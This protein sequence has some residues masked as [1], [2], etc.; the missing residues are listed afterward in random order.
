MD[1]DDDFEEEPMMRLDDLQSLNQAKVMAGFNSFFSK[2]P[3]F[4]LSMVLPCL[5]P[6]TN[7]YNVWLNI[8][9]SNTIFPQISASPRIST[10]LHH[11]V[12]FI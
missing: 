10:V 11:K 1:N 4:D 9:T 6:E 3:T 8:E 7:L 2:L 5:S 12:V